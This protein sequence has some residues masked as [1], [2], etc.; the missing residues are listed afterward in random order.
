MERLPESFTAHLFCGGSGL[1]SL[2]TSSSGSGSSPRA[3]RAVFSCC[4]FCKNLVLSWHCFTAKFCALLNFID[5]CQAEEKLSAKKTQCRFHSWSTSQTHLIAFLALKALRMVA[6][7]QIFSSTYSRSLLFVEQSHSRKQGVPRLYERGE[8]SSSTGKLKR[9]LKGQIES[10]ML[11]V[12][13]D[14]Q[15]C[16]GNLKTFKID[17]K[18]Q[19]RLLT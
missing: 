2:L 8:S 15:T 19:I 10:R 13:I 6:T 16:S 5:S 1:N 3:T 7:D 11:A 12:A 18:E 14:L 4:R 9:Q 17:R